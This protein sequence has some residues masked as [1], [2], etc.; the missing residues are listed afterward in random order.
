MKE[1]MRTLPSVTGFRLAWGLFVA[2]VVIPLPAAAVQFATGEVS[3]SI[4]TTLSYGTTWRVQDQDKDL[5]GIAATTL[6]N[7][8]RPPGSLGGRAFS[9][10]GDD[11][12]LNY[13]TGLV[14]NVLK[15]V[16]ELELNHSSGFGAFVRGRAFYDFENEDGDREKIDLTDPALDLVGSDIEFL[17]AYVYVQSDV[18]RHPVELRVGDQVVSWGE[19]TFIQNGINVINPIDVAAIRVP[20]AELRE[21]LLPEGMVWGS[22]GINENQSLEVFYQYDWSDTEPDPSGSYFSTND[23]ATDGGQRLML[24]FGQVPDIIPAGPRTSVALGLA[25]IGAV[26][27][28]GPTGRP[29]DSGQ[30]GIAYRALIPRL[31]DT[32]IGVYY[33]NYHSR[34]PIISARTG[35]LA[36]LSQGD[37]VGSARYFTE[38]P[39]DIKLYGLSFNTALGTGGW[40]LQGELSY[41]ED[42]P[43]QVDDVELLFAALSPLAIAEAQ[44]GAPGAGTLFAQNNQVAPGGVGFETVIPGFIERDIVQAQLTASNV[45][46]NVAGAN[47]LALIGEVGV[48]HVRDM[49]SQDELRLEVPGTYTSGNPLFTAAG[50]QPATESRENFADATSWGYQVRARLE[51]NNAIGPVTLL[52]AL[53]FRHDVNGNTPGPGGNFLE[54]RKAVTITLG[55]NYQNTITAEISYTNFSGAGRLNLINDRDFI[56]FNI[57]YLK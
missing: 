19:S 30:G 31:A 42:A 49:P 10:N 41:K 1:T 25:P 9:V 57:K 21:A 54:D 38:Y 18:G 36:G 2:I 26:V 8:S 24:G 50:V 45:F 6:P 7:G 48:T 20:G 51:Y 40:A 46:A 4:D 27:P 13:D 33:I 39:E 55:A 52:P 32:E 11:G 23:F 53:A 43:L 34:L 35:T 29:S 47:Q 22:L 16:S 12:N 14:S 56:S 28:R 37:Y 5:L 15:V 3:G 17:D 44:A